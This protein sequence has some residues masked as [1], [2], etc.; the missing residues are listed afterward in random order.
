[1]KV[2]FSRLLYFLI[3]PVALFMYFAPG[4]IFLIYFHERGKKSFGLRAKGGKREICY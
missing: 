3:R 2:F 1:M 4:T